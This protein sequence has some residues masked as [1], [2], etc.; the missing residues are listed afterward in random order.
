MVSSWRTA[1]PVSTLGETRGGS[2]RQGSVKGKKINRS[3]WMLLNNGGL[4]LDVAVA[5][6]LSTGQHF[7]IE[8]RAKSGTKSCF[9]LL[10]G[11][12]CS[13]SQWRHSGWSCTLGC[14]PF[15]QSEASHWYQLSPLVV[16]IYDWLFL[17][18]Q[19]LIF[20]LSKLLF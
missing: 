4:S 10:S 2:Y 13:S 3:H 14:C 20:Y 18:T 8:R 6:V 12:R 7:L 15:H 11:F 1:G 17:K 16:K 9:I 5:A 19:I